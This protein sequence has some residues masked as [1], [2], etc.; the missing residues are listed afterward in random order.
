MMTGPAMPTDNRQ[1]L[2]SVL[3]S[4]VIVLFVGR[5]LVGE[6]YAT[7]LRVGALVGFAVAFAVALF[8]VGE[9]LVAP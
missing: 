9:W 5:G 8:W 7:W 2:I 6:P 1:M 3:M 4:L